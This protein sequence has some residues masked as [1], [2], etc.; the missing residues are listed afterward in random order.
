MNHRH[1]GEMVLDT[2]AW[3]GQPGFN[4]SDEYKTFVC[5][6]D[7]SSRL[8]HLLGMALLD[9]DIRH[10]L[11]EARDETLLT[12]FGLSESTKKWI[13]TMRANTLADIA[14]EVAAYYQMT[15]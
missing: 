4:G 7:E 3:A 13:I 6:K 12:S 10:R 2:N 9:A 15:A 11:V 1:F 14:S 8:N 5:N